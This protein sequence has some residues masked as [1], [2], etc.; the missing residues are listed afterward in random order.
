MILVLKSDRTSGAS[1][2]GR[3]RKAALDLA[4]IVTSSPFEQLLQDVE[5]GKEKKQLAMQDWKQKAEEK[6][7]VLKVTM[8]LMKMKDICARNACE[9]DNNLTS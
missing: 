4:V 5:I 2:S 7:A 1:H 6:K 9:S 3:K 8:C